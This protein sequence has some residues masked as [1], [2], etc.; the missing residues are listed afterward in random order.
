M[1]IGVEGEDPCPP[2]IK[3]DNALIPEPE[4]D[5][6]PKPEADPDELLRPGIIPWLGEFE[7]KPCPSP[8]TG[9]P[10]FIPNPCPI[11]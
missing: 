2:L 4:A 10:M 5:P 7:P 11:P 9:W 3:A 1:V 8:Y 6:T